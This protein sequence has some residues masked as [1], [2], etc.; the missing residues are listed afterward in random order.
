MKG[1]K[2]VVATADDIKVC[3]RA[4]ELL[5]VVKS[6]LET[7][8]KHQGLEFSMEVTNDQMIF[9]LSRSNKESQCDTETKE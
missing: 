9:E 2:I 7:I 5:F 8:G 1:K 3:G 4:P 6:L